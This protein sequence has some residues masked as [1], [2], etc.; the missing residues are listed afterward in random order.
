MKFK[1]VGN[2]ELPVETEKDLWIYS[3]NL[4]SLADVIEKVQEKWPGVSLDKV[5]IEAY[6]HHQ[7]ATTYDIYDSSDYVDYIYISLEE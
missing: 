7:Y 2:D 3:N 1:S 5:Q 4:V 6:K